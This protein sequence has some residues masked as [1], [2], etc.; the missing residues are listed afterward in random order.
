MLAEIY[1]WFTEGFDTADLKN[2]T[3]IFRGGTT[4]GPTLT[5]GRAR[6][7]KPVPCWCHISAICRYQRFALEKGPN[8]C[9]GPFRIG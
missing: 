4:R 8:R 9:P 6:E 5:S 3:A 2:V 1:N 7:K